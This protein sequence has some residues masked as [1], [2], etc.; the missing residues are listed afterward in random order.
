MNEKTLVNDLTTGSVP[1]KLIIF[2]LPFMAANLMQALYNIVDMIIIGQ[3]GG[4]VG[5]SAVSIGGQVTNLLT[6]AGISIS[7]GGQ[8]FVSQLVG[9]GNTNKLK[10]A[11]GTQIS[12]ICAISVVLTVL[13]IVLH[14]FILSAMNTPAEAMEEACDY[15]VVCCLGFFFLYGYNAVCA[16]LR[17]M[18]ESVKPM[19]FAAIATAV[20]LALDLVFIA[21]MDM[22]AF[23]A[24]LA[25]SISQAV[26]FVSAIVYLYIRR[27]MFGFDFRPA[28]FRPDMDALKTI[29]K[30][31]IPLM[32]QQLAITLSMMYVTSYINDYGTVA[33]A[34]N[35]VGQKLYSIMSIVTSSLIASSA[36]MIGQSMGAKK[37]ERVPGVMWTCW[38]LCLAF[39]VV[40]AVI[41][42]FFPEEIFSIFNGEPEVLAMAPDYMHISILMFLSFA[43]MSPT[44]GLI[45][46]VGFTTLNLVIALADGV[47]ARIALSLL[48]GITAGMGLNGFFLGNA[49][50]GFVSVIMGCAYYFSGRWR[51]RQLLSENA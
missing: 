24:A 40:L 27:N 11:I 26:S 36:A 4:S 44:L 37:P 19:I 30:L 42:W 14:R 35:G 6:I 17:G 12:A 8:I 47:V 23:G 39:W 34:V 43:L 2:S 10:S 48:L 49:L 29:M 28:S 22:G 15:L 25:T 45:N 16:I 31:G 3:F 9:A 20:N 13:G 46:G 38:G 7:T 50:A 51:N 41:S 33:S 18:G 21:G 32:F 1:K 5:L